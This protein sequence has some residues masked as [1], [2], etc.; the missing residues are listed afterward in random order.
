MLSAVQA[1]YGSASFDAVRQRRAGLEVLEAQHVLAPADRV[2]GV[3]KHPVVRSDRG[4]ADV[5][6][7][8]ALGHLVGVE[9]ELL[10]RIERAGLARV[11]RVFLAGLEARVVPVAAQ[12][13]RDG[14][15]VLLDAADDLLVHLVLERLRVGGHCR[16]VGVLGL[17]VADDVLVGARVVAEPVVLVG[18]VAVRRLDDVGPHGCNRWR[19]D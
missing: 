19:R 9:H 4:R 16:L 3:D 5:E 13:I 8:V 7:A 15:V 6:E 11:D 17:E 14:R 10:G 12:A 18:P 2:L 1:R